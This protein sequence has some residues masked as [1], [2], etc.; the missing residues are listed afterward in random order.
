MKKSKELDK[1]IRTTSFSSMV[2]HSSA[3]TVKFV[4]NGPGEALAAA[5]AAAVG[6]TLDGRADRRTA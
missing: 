1:A 2:S 4:V 6:T 5:A 3:L